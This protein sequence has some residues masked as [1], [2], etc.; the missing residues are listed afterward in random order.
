MATIPL[1]T[2]ISESDLKRIEDTFCT[3]HTK[4]IYLL[5]KDTPPS[6]LQ[7][8]KEIVPSMSEEEL[9]LLLTFGGVFVNGAPSHDG[10][11]K[12]IAP[13]RIECFLPK[14]DLRDPQKFFPA[15]DP[16]WIIY[17]DQF[18]LVCWKP[19]GLPTIPSREQRRYNLKSYLDQ[20]LAKKIH[21]PS[22]LDMS[23][24]GIVLVSADPRSNAPIQ[25]LYDQQLIRKIYYLRTTGK[26]QS[27][28]ALVDAP[29]GKHPSHP[30]LR[31]IREDGQQAKTYFRTLSVESQHA[32]Y[33]GTSLI[34]AKPITGRT[35]QI[36]VHAAH[37]GI[38]ILGDSFYSGAIHNEGLHLMAYSLRFPHPISR[39]EME[40]VAPKRLIPAW[41][42]KE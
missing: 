9:Q 18:I 14:F 21:M 32:E 29:I 37:H 23:T 33:S 20:H 30:V 28:P 38:P 34:E 22:R 17:E 10:T 42:K 7:A 1:H 8:L 3:R 2:P 19:K 35:H 39:K 12:L 25:G 4:K 6:L 26:L 41:A 24:C 13:L 16:S 15:F 27:E 31:V 36:R 40:V 5:Q 11:Q